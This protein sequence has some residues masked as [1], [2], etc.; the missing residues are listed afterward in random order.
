MR[1]S[2]IHRKAVVYKDI[3]L[4][5]YKYT[6]VYTGK[7]MYTTVCIIIFKTDLEQPLIASLFDGITTSIAFVVTGHKMTIPFPPPSPSPSSPLVGLP[8]EQG[9]IEILSIH[10]TQM[11]KHGKLAASVNL[12]ELAM[13]TK[14]F[15]GAEIEGLVRSAQATA[16]NKMI[17]V[18]LSFLICYTACV[19]PPTSCPSH[20]LPHPPPRPRIR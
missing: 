16:M 19:T 5:L 12:D 3:H 9:R 6:W 8:D 1:I 17:K 18:C 7:L 15:S 14:N 11:R 10:T 13:R 2:S 20:F 4:G